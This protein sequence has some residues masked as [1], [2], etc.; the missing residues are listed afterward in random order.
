MLSIKVRIYVSGIVCMLFFVVYFLF[1]NV[2]IISIIFSILILFLFIFLILIFY[3]YFSDIQTIEKLTSM[4]RENNYDY[5]PVFVTKE[6]QGIVSSIDKLK[7]DI[8]KFQDQSFSL[9]KMRNDFIYLVSHE[10]RTPVTSSLGYIGILKSSSTMSAENKKILERLNANISDL[11]NIVEEIL[12]VIFLESNEFKLNNSA[13]KIKDVLDE[14]LE[15][16]KNNGISIGFSYNGPQ[17][18]VNIDSG[19]FKKIINSILSNSIKFNKKEGVISITV[20]TEN[21]FFVVKIS[22]SGIGI[23][24]E[25]LLNLFTPF[26]RKT[27]ILDFD[28][29]GLGLGLYISKI[30][31]EKMGGKI[32]VSSSLNKGSSFSLYF[33]Y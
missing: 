4:I 23:P 14:I 20:F 29:K 31:I 21:K 18:F 3:H 11:E 33:P 15:S 13:V 22:D 10:L 12:S 17:D 27:S 19:L 28:Y 16:F 30:S 2:S 1:F 8:S 9:D 25:D 24:K 5:S 26:V 6:L 7:S 32:N